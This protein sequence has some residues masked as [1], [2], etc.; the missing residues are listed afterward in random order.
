MKVL[1]LRTPLWAKTTKEHTGSHVQ[2][3]RYLTGQQRKW[4]VALYA[5]THS[6]GSLDW[7]DTEQTPTP[8]GTGSWLAP[9]LQKTQQ[10]ELNF[11]KSHVMSHSHTKPTLNSSVMLYKRGTCLLMCNNHFKLMFCKIYFVFLS[12][13]YISCDPMTRL[14]NGVITSGKN[15][16][17]YQM[18]NTKQTNPTH[19]RMKNV[20]LNQLT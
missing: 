2:Q 9:L 5:L 3:A 13:L 18:K 12:K 15:S 16:T 10:S 14:P 19:K 17:E 20:C 8:T 6:W 11:N 1:S 4:H 7:Q